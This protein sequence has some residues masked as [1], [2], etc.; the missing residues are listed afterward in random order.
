MLALPASVRNRKLQDYVQLSYG[1]PINQVHSFNQMQQLLRDRDLILEMESLKELALKKVE[2]RLSEATTPELQQQ[3]IADLVA[4]PANL[5][6]LIQ[7]Q[8][9]VSASKNLDQI[10]KEDAVVALAETA[11]AKTFGKD[12]N[13]FLTAFPETAHPDLLD[14]VL[15]HRLG[16]VLGDYDQV[17]PDVR[18]AA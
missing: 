3:L 7:A 4:D 13:A 1:N 12:K 17:S 10:R 15:A 5:K 9:D 16:N 11:T 8:A 2:N 18:Q 14:I 6:I